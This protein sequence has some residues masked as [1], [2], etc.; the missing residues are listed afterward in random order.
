MY[1]ISY[2]YYIYFVYIGSLMYFVI[3]VYFFLCIYVDKEVQVY[4]L[5]VYFYICV[6]MLLRVYF[7][8]FF[9]RFSCSI[10]YNLWNL[11]K[12]KKVCMNVSLF[13]CMVVM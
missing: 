7:G 4:V 8:Y 11:C 12:I 9:N 1:I 5:C 6:C 3:N 13:R 2:L 10:Y